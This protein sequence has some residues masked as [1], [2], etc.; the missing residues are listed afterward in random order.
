[1]KTKPALPPMADFQIGAQVTQV[2]DPALVRG[3]LEML[4][5]HVCAK[6]EEEATAVEKAAKDKQPA[7]STP[8]TVSVRNRLVVRGGALDLGML[9]MGAAS[10]P[11]GRVR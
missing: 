1:M 9:L 7:P 2:T 6:V 3:Q 10:G 8:T 4:L 11:G 5:A